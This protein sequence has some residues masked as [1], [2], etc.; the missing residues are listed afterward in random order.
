MSKVTPNKPL[1]I[2][3]YGFPGAGKTFFARQLC[4]ELQAAHV[5]GDRIRHE[6]FEEPKHDKS[7]NAIV[8]QLMDYMTNEFLNAGVSVIYD[9]NLM[10]LAQRRT[11]R[12]LARK[13][14]V[15]PLL[16]WIQ[17]DTESAF[18]RI[19][20][21]DRRKTDDKYSMILDRTT[22]DSVISHMQNPETSEDYIVIS[23]K[24]TYSTQQSAVMKRLRELG[25]IGSDQ[26]NSK[27]IRPDLVNIIPNPTAGR[28]DMN[29]RNIVIR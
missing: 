10:R 18:A 27:V 25:L 20:V 4:D 7:E 15:Q 13:L 23:G 6:L 1:L 11:L 12:D 22:F 5:Q 29:R 14:H 19:A 26:A 24:H 17:I 28:V 9:T 2:L 16:I 3:L 21:R 8:T